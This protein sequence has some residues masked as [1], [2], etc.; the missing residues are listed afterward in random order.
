MQKKHQLF[1]ILNTHFMGLKHHLIYFCP[2]PVEALE[3]LE[4]ELESIIRYVGAENQPLFLVSTLNCSAVAPVPAKSIH[5][6]F[7]TPV[8][9][10]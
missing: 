10:F 7:L 6:N 1:I 4:L 3:T 2:R 8:S 5:G 9:N